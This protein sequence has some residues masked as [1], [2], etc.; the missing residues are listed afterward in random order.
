MYLCIV[1]YCPFKHI[2]T[3]N[4]NTA[5]L[6]HIP[7]NLSLANRRTLNASTGRRLVF[8][9]VW[10]LFASHV[11]KSLIVWGRQWTERMMA[12]AWAAVDSIQKIRAKGQGGLMPRIFKH[13]VRQHRPTCR[14][15]SGSGLARKCGPQR[16]MRAHCLWRINI[17][18][19]YLL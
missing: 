15:G 7:S 3:I 5:N 9:P 10:P 16:S 1:K 17:Y 8:T 12:E 4:I 19:I 18:S 14:R 2:L 6:C 11:H 13:L